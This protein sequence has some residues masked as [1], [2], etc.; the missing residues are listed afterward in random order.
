MKT[1]IRITFSLIYP[2]NEYFHKFWLLEPGLIDIK[3]SLCFLLVIRGIYDEC[4]ISFWFTDVSAYY[5]YNLVYLCRSLREQQE[6]P[7]S[8][9]GRRTTSL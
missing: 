2:I 3:V 9:M 5:V 4:K 1:F 7:R 8:I 6:T